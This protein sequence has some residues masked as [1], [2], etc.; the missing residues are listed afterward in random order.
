MIYCIVESV[1]LN[2]SDVSQ[3]TSKLDRE[4]G[5]ISYDVDFKY[6]GYE[7]D[8]DIDAISGKILNKQVEIDD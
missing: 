8:Y 5:A 7:Y 3:L 4:N 6:N 2:M 1:K